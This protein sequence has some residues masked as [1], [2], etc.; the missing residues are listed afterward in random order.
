MLM[1]NTKIALWGTSFFSRGLAVFVNE[2]FLSTARKG[3]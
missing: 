1:S 2:A 3:S